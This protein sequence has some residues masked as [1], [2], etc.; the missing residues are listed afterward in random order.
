MSPDVV[1]MI[2]VILILV[3]TTGAI[4]LGPRVVRWFGDVRVA[5]LLALFT[6]KEL[7]VCYSWNRPPSFDYSDPR[8]RRMIVCDLVPPATNLLAEQLRSKVTP[9]VRIRVESSTGQVYI[10]SSNPRILWRLPKRVA[11]DSPSRM[12]YFKRT[13]LFDAE[14]KANAPN[15]R[16]DG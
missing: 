11:I 3:V 8:T 12:F 1:D 15:N 5:G 16:L 2:I 13:A 9:S 10:S 7:S 4:T 14:A 6:Q